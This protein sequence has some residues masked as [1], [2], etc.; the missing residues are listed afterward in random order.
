MDSLRLDSKRLDSLH[1]LIGQTLCFGWRGDTPAESHTVNAHAR[2]LV[3]EMQVAGVI[4]MGRNIESPEQVRAT[5][6]EL[7]SRSRIP[8][9]VGTDQEGG[10]VNRFGLPFHAFPGNMALGAIAERAEQLAQRQ[11]EAQARELRAVGVNWNFAPSVDVNNNP[12]N[13][14]IGVR[15][16]GED[17]ALVARLGAAAIRGL[18]N[19]GM[20]ACAKHFPGHG[21]TTVDSHHA[22]PTVTGDRE[23]LDSVE[24]A[25]FRAA[26]QAGVGSIMTSHILFPALDSERPAT[27][28]PA[29]LT[30]LLRNEMGYDG[31]VITDCLEMD[32]IAG[33]IGTARGAVEAL[34]AGADMVL[35]CHSLHNHW[36]IVQVIREAVESGDLPESRLR[37]AAVRVLAAKRR[38]LENRPPV[39]ESPWLDPEINELENEIARASI[40][41]VR[42]K[43]RVLRGKSLGM[44]SAHKC[45][46]DFADMIWPRN[47]ARVFTANL[48]AHFPRDGEGF[49]M[50]RIAACKQCLVLTTSRDSGNGRPID[51]ERQAETVRALHGVFGERLIVVALHEPYDIR[52]FPEVRNYVCTY[53]SNSSTLRALADALL[54]GFKFIGRLPVTIPGISSSA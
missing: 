13:P 49:A 41:V 5:V 37:E 20:M 16:Y 46:E 30:G 23:R 52:R 51:P 9:L 45:L 50:A 18:Q 40:T 7:Q 47:H 21:N 38:F 4:L 42:G 22:L 32:A 54:G 15:S 27:L 43:A 34:K 29:V 44:L 36:L 39:E 31:L 53:R 35:A 14:I 11:G 17:P 48:P 1:V 28:S 8:L 33:S 3:E 24:L 6:A 12:D 2:E 19:A 26:I 10:L 25:P